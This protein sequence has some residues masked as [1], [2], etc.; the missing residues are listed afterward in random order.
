VMVHCF[1]PTEINVFWNHCN[2]FNH[3]EVFS[4]CIKQ[5]RIKKLRS[6]VLFTSLVIS[7]DT[8]LFLQAI[9]GAPSVT[10]PASLSIGIS[11][12]CSTFL[13]TSYKCAPP[14]HWH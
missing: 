8:S 12:L 14:F 4:W 2:N 7:K 3:F 11:R 5:W 9:H 10:S 6:I 13:T 1:W